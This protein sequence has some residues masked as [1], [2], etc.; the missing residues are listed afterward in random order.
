MSDVRH[1]TLPQIELLL[2]AIDEEDRARNRLSL[3]VARA[4]QSTE[5]SFKKI[6]R[7][8]G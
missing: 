2:A 6:L 3:I 7:E 4:A 5:D 1:Y 8:I